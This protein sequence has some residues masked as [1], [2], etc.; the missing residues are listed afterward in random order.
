MDDP[1]VT[2]RFKALLL[3][4]AGLVV[5]VFI[6]WNIG[7][8]NYWE[9][10][11]GTA[12]FGGIFIAFFLGRF[13]WVLTIASSFLTGAIPALG[14]QITP[15]E[16]LVAFGIAKFFVEDIVLRRARFKLGNR[17]DLFLIA[18]FMAIITVHAVHDR[19]GMKFLGSTVWGGHNYVAVYVGLAAYFVIQ[20]IPMQSRV[21]AKLPYVVLAVT[22]FDLLIGVITTISPS[23]VFKIFPFYNAVSVAGIEEA[24]TGESITGR[25]VSFGNF[26]FILILLVLASIPLWQI[27]NPKNLLLF[28]CLI[29]GSV[30]ALFSGFRTMVANTALGFLVAGIRD[31]K[32]AIVLLLPFLA[33][34]LFALS[35]IN[36][37]VFHLPRQVQRGLAFLPGK[38]DPDMVKD[39]ESSNDFR[40]RVWTLWAW[41]YFP[42]HPWMGRG[43]GFSRD[44]AKANAL[45]PKGTDYR[46]VVEV[47]N[48][49]NGLFAALDTFGIV[50]TIFF[51]LWNLRILARTL[52][53][54]FQRTD[55]AGMV[56]RFLALY[57]TVWI[58][59][60]WLG[61]Q[62]IG[63][64]LPQQFAVVAV[65]LRLQE[66]IKA[67][68]VRVPQSAP[69][70]HE[71]LRE[72]VASG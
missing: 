56:L 24:L 63:P 30:A 64:W 29:V 1:A 68:L 50:G 27:L 9:L 32:Y 10:I 4:A 18:A 5:A 38:W 66:N 52:R 43:F 8:G 34:G 58:G 25:V 3:C 60:F 61:A 54:S 6:G 13:F 23:L 70:P 49:H 53:V 16:I 51:V 35:Y 44:W 37:E 26:G 31:L 12:V 22:S 28:I 40:R 15:F 33:F 47:Q 57:L 2:Q 55:A 7:S 48:I 11:L 39:A 17:F 46:Q 14:G 67:D 21:W 69:S 36:S 19:F 72:E 59:S 41:E 45:N 62:S 20:S 65:F 42:V 71:A